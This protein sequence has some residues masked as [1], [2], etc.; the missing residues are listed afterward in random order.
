MNEILVGS[1]AV[2][3]GRLT[4]HEL[5]RW[6]RRIYHGIYVPKHAELTLRDRAVA[7][8]L[9]SGRRGV[10]AG[11]AAAGLHGSAWIDLQTPI[12][13][14]G[15][16]SRPQPG[17]VPRGDRFVD[18]DITHINGLAVTTAARTGF[19]LG[20]R[21]GR[22]QALARLDALARCRGFMI[23]ELQPII[24]RN[25]RAR[26]LRQLREL[27]PLVD[28]G[29]Q[30]PRESLTRLR[31]IDA[32]FPIPQTQI[33]IVDD[34]R[35]VAYLDMG[36]EEF[37]VAVE[38]DGDQH[39]TDRRQYVKDIRRSRMLDALDWISIRVVAEDHPQDVL[40]RVYTALIDRGC[41][42]DIDEMQTRTRTFAA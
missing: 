39:R 23:D 18:E 8:W 6:Y 26:G 33:P 9:A 7:A 32:G 41:H 16:T 2:A 28:A 22:A 10:I 35:I 3:A 25:A 30:S 42:L 14:L 29:A 27:L 21:G 13:I 12:E 20:R 11:V 24:E 36:W 1:E 15:V 17:L 4:R 34:G 19:D 31:L 37:K 5:S 38:Y 40:A